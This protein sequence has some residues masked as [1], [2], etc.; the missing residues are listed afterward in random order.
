MVT[1]APSDSLGGQFRLTAG[2]LST[3]KGDLRWA[4]GLGGDWYLKLNLGY[5]EGDDFTQDR[6]FGT[7][8]PGLPREAARPSNEYDTSNLSLRLDRDSDDYLFTLEGGIN[9]NHGGTVVTG[10]GRVQLEDLDR[11]FFRANFTTDHFNVQAYQN[12]RES[13]NQL[14]TSSGGRIFLDTENRKVELQTNW[15]FN[16]GKVRLVAGASYE[17]EEIDTANNQ[18]IQTLVFAPVDHD[19]Q[20]VYA[21][22]DF[23]LTDAVKLVLA[24][25]WDDSSLHDSQV[26]P[27]AALVWSVNSNNTLRF[28]YNSAFQVANYSEFFLDAPTAF[29]A[30]SARSTCPASKPPCARPSASPA[31]SEA[32]FASARSVTRHS[33]SKRS[34]AS[35]SATAAS[36]AAR[37]S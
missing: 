5:S 17:E 34:R 10:I 33:T 19:F 9:D 12:T 2:E 11:S 20:G 18:G 25:R 16:D 7:E 30:R 22:V 6:R 21:Q 35:R 29:R 8:Y 1:K 32:R 37:P 26:S 31:A 36:S 14:A 27:K 28:S 3:L 15:D 24:G 13:P 23:D 4:T